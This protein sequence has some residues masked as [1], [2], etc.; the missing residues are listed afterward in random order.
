MQAR[1]KTPALSVAGELEHRNLDHHG[2]SR[3]VLRGGLA[4]EEGWPL[5]LQRFAGRFGT[6]G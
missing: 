6:E 1:I 2:D 3:W 5:S 4:G